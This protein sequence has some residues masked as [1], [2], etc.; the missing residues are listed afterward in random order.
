MESRFQRF[1]LHWW[2]E[3][4]QDLRLQVQM[5]YAGYAIVYNWVWFSFANTRSTQ[6]I[7]KGLKGWF[8]WSLASILLQKGKKQSDQLPE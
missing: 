6:I 8:Q 3:Y 2:Y 5:I 7:I 4:T 1:C